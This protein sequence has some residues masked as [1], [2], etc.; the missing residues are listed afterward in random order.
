MAKER[1]SVTI[2]QKLA[3]EIQIQ[4]RH[5]KTSRSQL[6]EQILLVW[7]KQQ[8]KDQLIKGYQSLA[9]ENLKIARAFSTLGEG[10][11]PDE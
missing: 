5:R 11:W 10:V 3:W 4:A 1:F 6:I 7:Q 8:K 9:E 2:D